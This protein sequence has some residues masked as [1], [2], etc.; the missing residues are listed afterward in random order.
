[1]S[2]YSNKACNHITRPGWFLTGKLQ[3]TWWRQTKRVGAYVSQRSL[4]QRT[5]ASNHDWEKAEFTWGYITKEGSE[6]HAL[7]HINREEDRVWESVDLVAP[8]L[9]LQCTR[10]NHHWIKFIVQTMADESCHDEGCCVLKRYITQT[11][12][13]F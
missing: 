10:R 13:P 9:R 12:A 5:A 2:L 3:L 6:G 8:Q 11:R 4:T 1:M 7:A